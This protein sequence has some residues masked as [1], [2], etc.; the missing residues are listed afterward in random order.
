MQMKH[1]MLGVALAMGCQMAL[2]DVP[3]TDPIG[4]RGDV[5]GLWF[6]PEL[7][8]QGLQVDVLDAGRAA[9]TWYTFDA[10]GR[11]LWLTGLGSVEGHVIEVEM[12]SSTGGR[13]ATAEARPAP[14]KT[15]RGTLRLSFTGCD[16]ASLEF[17]AADDGLADGALELQR[18]THPQGTRCN[19]EEEFAEQRLISFEHGFGRFEVLFADLPAENQETYELGYGYTALPAPLQAR[20]GLHL[21]GVNRSDDLIM[22]IKAPVDGLQP[23]TR[24]LV[25]L[26][27]EYATNEPYGC[28]GVGGSPGEAVYVKLGALGFEPG[29]VRVGEGEL[30]YLRPNFDFGSQAASG[31]HGLVVGDMANSRECGEGRRWE[32]K[33]ATSHGTPLAARSDA[34]GRLWVLAGTDSGFESRTDVY[35]TALRVRL[36]PIADGD[37]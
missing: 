22:A 25:E 31:E 20:R 26:E 27:V 9:V 17:E 5:G 2:A 3:G 12:A 6:N 8:G 14:V 29:V 1:R 32:L 13:F 34:E 21:T 16:S 24:Y 4:L 15:P 19:G 23:E 18:L 10:D 36:R 28:I 37:E 30:D 33:T 7:D 35:Y 11:P